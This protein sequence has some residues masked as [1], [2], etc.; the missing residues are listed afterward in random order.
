M[1]QE[2]LGKTSLKSGEPRTEGR[3][4]RTGNAPQISTQS[5]DYNTTETE[6]VIDPFLFLFPVISI[7]DMINRKAAV[8]RKN[9]L[10]KML[11]QSTEQR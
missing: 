5:L 3:R 2:E 9:F 4:R 10:K 7:N 11:K 6:S 1:I 8:R